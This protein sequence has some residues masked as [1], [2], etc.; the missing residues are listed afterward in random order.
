M[1]RIHPALQKE[2]RSDSV[3]G[4]SFKKSLVLTQ[5]GSIPAIRC[6]NP[7]RV[8]NSENGLWVS[9]KSAF[10]PPILISWLYA[11]LN[12]AMLLGGMT[13]VKT[14]GLSEPGNFFGNVYL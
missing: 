11:F 4:I 1:S 9:E 5:I 14:E 12:S 7:S 2:F 6:G 10:M 8:R 13:L 3:F